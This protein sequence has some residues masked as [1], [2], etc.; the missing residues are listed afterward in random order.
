MA[1]RHRARRRRPYRDRQTGQH[2]A[3]AH[4][5]PPRSTTRPTDPRTAPHP[6]PGPRRSAH[7]K[8]AARAL[9]DPRDRVTRRSRTAAPRA[10]RDLPPDRRGPARSPVSSL[11]WAYA[12]PGPLD[13]PAGS[14][15]HGRGRRTDRG[16]PTREP[17]AHHGHVRPGV[18]GA[19]AP[20][21]KPAAR[22]VARRGPQPTLLT[23]AEDP[24]HVPHQ[25][26]R[27]AHPARRTRP[28]PLTGLT[29]APATVYTELTGRTE[30]TTAA[31]LALASGLG[32]STTS[33]ALVTLEE[34]GLALRTPAATTA[35]CA[36]RP[37]AR[38]PTLDTTP[39]SGDDTEPDT[40]TTNDTT[41]P[42][43][44]GDTE[45]EEPRR[46]HP[47]GDPDEP[48][49]GTAPA[50]DTPP[51]DDEPEQDGDGGPESDTPPPH[52]VRPSPSRDPCN[53]SP[54]RVT[55]TASRPAPCAS[56]S[57][58]TSRTTPARRSPPPGS[59]A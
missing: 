30:P 32:R 45:N 57:S 37:L 49:A 29:G 38:R 56:W 5:T 1:P 41:D 48:D 53:W 55:R 44:S 22:T 50:A 20:E 33:K 27:H 26:R 52:R 7:T 25:P 19:H 21:R 11:I 13:F 58:T 51:Q 10:V 46:G 34:H 59:A 2:L 8:T 14:S 47:D 6:P 23:E 35:P 9:T 28:Q 18:R 43:A 31:E 54:H 24:T 3:A 17:R 40:P 4:R 42:D 12:I 36:P 15:V 16:S 39:N